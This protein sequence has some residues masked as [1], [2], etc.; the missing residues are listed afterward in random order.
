MLHREVW[1][2]VMNIPTEF[3]AYILRSEIV[4]KK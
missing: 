2:M 3:A 4:H 1:Y